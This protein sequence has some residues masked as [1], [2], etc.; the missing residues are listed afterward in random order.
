MLKNYQNFLENDNFNQ[1]RIMLCLCGKFA[2]KLFLDITVEK[3]SC[4]GNLLSLF[5]KRQEFWVSVA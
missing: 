1:R 2:L 5:L 4:R 3:T